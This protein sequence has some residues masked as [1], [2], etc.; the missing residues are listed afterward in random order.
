[1]MSMVSGM[2]SNSGM[3]GEKYMA[4]F[5]SGNQVINIQSQD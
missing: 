1:M 4:N 3:N 5:N 2:Q